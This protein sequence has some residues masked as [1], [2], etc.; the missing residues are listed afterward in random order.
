[1]PIEDNGTNAFEQGNI[2]KDEYIVMR[3][4]ITIG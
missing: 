2:I 3:S 4:S 1:M